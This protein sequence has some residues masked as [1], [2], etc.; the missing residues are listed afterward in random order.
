MTTVESL[1]TSL[2]IQQEITNLQARLIKVQHGLIVLQQHNTELREELQ[3]IANEVVTYMDTYE[4]KSH[5]VELA[6]MQPQ[7]REVQVILHVKS[8][9][10]SAVEALAE[11]EGFQSERMLKARMLCNHEFNSK[12][13]NL[14]LESHVQEIMKLQGSLIKM[15]DNLIEAHHDNKYLLSRRDYIIEKQ[16]R[17]VKFM[18]KARISQLE[19]QSTM[20]EHKLTSLMQDSHRS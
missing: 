9:H 20:L 4:P 12:K 6:E 3:Q 7:L 15:Q 13:L 8:I 1:E 19:T 10:E 18:H 17:F 2:V 16:T 5:E 11:L 14:S